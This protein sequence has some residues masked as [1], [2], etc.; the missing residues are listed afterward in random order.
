MK[1]TALFAAASLALAGAVFTTGCDRDKTASNT[2]DNRT[3]GQKTSDAIAKAGEKTG[4][5][6]GT[7]V[8]KTKDATVAAG[9]KLKATTQPSADAA[10]KDARDTLASAV[11]AAVTNNGMGDLV[12]R[13]TKVDRDRIGKVDK[14]TLGDLNT[15]VDKFNADWK[16]KYNADFK[17]SD[18]EAAVFGSPV[19]VRV[20]AATDAARLAAAKT[21]PNDTTAAN[22]KSLNNTVVATF[23]AEGGAKPVDVTLLNEGTVMAGYK[24]DAPDTLTADKLKANLIHHLQMVNQMKDQWPADAT[25]AGRIVSHHIMEAIMDKQ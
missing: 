21:G 25:E 13:F 8:D 12:E 3:A 15:V 22:D 2:T 4:D 20:G 6:V 16:A 9:D 7:A 11:Q 24:I 17:I 18:K 1:A 10:L 23:P 5:A 14:N 19:A